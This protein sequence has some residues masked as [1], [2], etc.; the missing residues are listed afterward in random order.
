MK[1]KKKKNEHIPSWGGGLK[2]AEES[3]IWATKDKKKFCKLKNW[4]HNLSK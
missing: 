3:L 4:A 2:P 1:R